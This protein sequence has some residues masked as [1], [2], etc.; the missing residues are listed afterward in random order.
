MTS[1]P[2]RPCFASR[3]LRGLRTAGHW[4]LLAFARRGLVALAWFV[5][6]SAPAQT[7]LE[8]ARMRGAATAQSFDDDPTSALPKVP[9]SL[10]TSTV[11]LLGTDAALARWGGG[12]MNERDFGVGLA[13]QLHHSKLEQ[14]RVPGLWGQSWAVALNTEF[15]AQS[16]RYFGFGDALAQFGTLATLA[17]A[18]HA[19]YFRFSGEM[20]V[21]GD[22][23]NSIGSG[24]ASIP[25]GLRFKVSG[26]ALEL[27][28]APAL[29]WVS[30][31]QDARQFTTGPLFFGGQAKWQTN[32]G[33]LQVQHL[34]GVS[35]AEA[36]VTTLLACGHS[37]VIALCAEG[38]WLDL[39]DLGQ[40]D[41]ARF[42]RIGFR[43]GLGKWSNEAERVMRA[44]VVPLN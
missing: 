22:S 13:A 9:W 3:K 23:K 35:P 41:E 5:S 27:G 2:K 37:G 20:S 10:E 18:G 21:F 42:A 29:G 38:S 26:S 6:S 15:G 25:F 24:F 39:H 28:A 14:P 8:Q 33:W 17:A 12:S 11:G 43:I 4:A 30:A 44:A 31:F 36:A 34:S 32:A 7:M 1:A 40:R 16:R 19:L